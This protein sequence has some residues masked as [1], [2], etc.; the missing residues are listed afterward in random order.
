MY[1]INF[2]RSTLGV[3]Y[4]RSRSNSQ[5][6]VYRKV[7]NH[8]KDCGGKAS[9]RNGLLS[10]NDILSSKIC[11]GDPEPQSPVVYQEEMYKL[12][13]NPSNSEDFPEKPKR[14][15]S[16]NHI[17]MTKG[18]VA[19]SENEQR[20][21]EIKNIDDL[22]FP[23]RSLQKQESTTKAAR[24][25]K[26]YESWQFQRA[27]RSQGSDLGEE[28]KEDFFD[29]ESLAKSE[30]DDHLGWEC[31]FP[32]FAGAIRN[33]SKDDIYFDAIQVSSREMS[34]LRLRNQL[35][36]CRTEVEIEKNKNRELQYKLQ[37]MENKLK[38]VEKSQET[39]IGSILQKQKIEEFYRK[40]LH[41]E[42]KKREEF[43]A[44]LQKAQEEKQS[45]VE[46]MDVLIFEYI[47]NISPKFKDIGP[48][49]YE[50]NES[51]DS[52]GWYKLGGAL[53]EGYYGSVRV[54]THAK[55]DEE[56]AVKILKKTNISRFKDLKQIAE[57]IH[58]LKTYRHPNII[59]LEEVIHATDNIYVVTE[60]CFMD[61]HKYNSETGL[62]LESAREVING[63]LHPLHHLHMHG[64]CHLDLKPEN[65]LLKKSLHSHNASYTDVRICDF[66]LVS[67]A[68]KTEKNKD[69]IREGYAC[70]TPG[71]YAP[72]MVLT[73]KFEGR[74]ADMVST[75]TCIPIN[76]FYFSILLTLNT[77][78]FLSSGRWVA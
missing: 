22:R 11:R 18:M 57:E 26:S 27:E 5:S 50:V 39:K 37:L 20:E 63:I 60:R 61:L 53:G 29:F 48:V 69:I 33:E 24:F 74:T 30:L 47:P 55:R 49:D 64:I 2:R 68:N 41:G 67:M 40:A 52:V 7:K 34:D 59:H 73:E 12:N 51:F 43:E 75:I 16:R 71:F 15:I 77:F 23:P 31:T 21:K 35:E 17:T 46:Q 9:K 32:S 4:D 13:R 42:I 54:G 28:K 10:A 78:C 66:G 3:D 19:R 58:V 38:A 25:E 76:S 72:E 56:Y 1:C 45:Y 6:D 62:T 8:L 44:A 36:Q 70:G 14:S 65:I